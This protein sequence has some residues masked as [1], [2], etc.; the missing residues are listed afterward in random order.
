MGPG[1]EALVVLEGE[2][3]CILVVWPLGSCR[4]LVGCWAL[5]TQVHPLGSLGS[6]AVTELPMTGTSCSVAW[7]ERLSVVQVLEVF[8]YVHIT[9]CPSTT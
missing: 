1:H 8:S 2:E 7:R 9:K 3:G 4:H 5:V 6:P